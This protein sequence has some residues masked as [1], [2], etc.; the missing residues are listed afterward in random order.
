ML[1]MAQLI[2]AVRKFRQK[3]VFQ[4]FFI[5]IFYSVSAQ[6][7]SGG[8]TKWEIHGV[9]EIVTFALF[10]PKSLDNAL[11]S[12]LSFVPAHLIEMPEIMEYIKEHPEYS[13]W[14]FSIIEITRQK[15]FIIDG[16][17]L[18]IEKDD[19]IGLW[20]APVDASNLAEKIPSEAFNKI[21]KPALG[22]VLALGV[23]VPD[24]DY[25]AYMKSKGHYGEY[26]D[27]TMITDSAKTYSGQIRFD[28]L[29]LRTS[30]RPLGVER[31]D[32]TV[33]IQL[34]FFKD[35][36][37]INTI[38]VSGSDAVHKNC[39]A[40]WSVAG[41]HPLSKAVLVGPTFLTTY[42]QPLKG[43]LYKLK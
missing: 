23:W 14:A 25:V 2:T 37:V 18:K 27:V 22:S 35:I 8:I 33:G 16:R 12:G 19:A 28:N 17:A 41:T 7:P 9:E 32:S 6:L 4:F 40:E 1:R 43:S 21:I 11:P 42:E 29:E 30:A 10:D 26:G 5:T 15:A 24:R 38:V 34:M 20:F 3:L 31:K 13:D 39:N 36:E